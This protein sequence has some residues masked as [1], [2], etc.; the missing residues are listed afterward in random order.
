M[1]S[2]EEGKAERDPVN[3]CKCLR[4]EYEHHRRCSVVPSGQDKKGKCEGSQTLGQ[5]AQR[6]DGLHPWSYSNPS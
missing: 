5:A 2:L 4:G 1:C 6:D 3:M